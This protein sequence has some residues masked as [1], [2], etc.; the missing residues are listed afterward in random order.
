[1]ISLYDFK[2][3]ESD[4]TSIEHKEDLFVA[5][6]VNFALLFEL[7]GTYIDSYINVYYHDNIEKIIIE[8]NKNDYKQKLIY[9][10]TY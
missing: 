10:F 4:Y 5:K 6:I 9:T 2:F 3:N 7:E 1:M 8:T